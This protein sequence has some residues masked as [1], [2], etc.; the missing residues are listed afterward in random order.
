MNGSDIWG[1]SA[2]HGDVLS[3]FKWNFYKRMSTF[4][5]KLP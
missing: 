5:S 3:L 1:S 4:P 2:P